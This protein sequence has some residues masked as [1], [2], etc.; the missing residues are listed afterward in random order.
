MRVLV[1]GA[2]AVGCAFYR[3]LEQQKGNE[4]T[5]LVRAGRKRGF[6]RFKILDARTGEMRTRERPL[7]VE[8][9]QARPGYDTVLFCVRADQLAAA[10]DD[11]GE[12]PAGAR[13]ATIT[14]GRDGLALLRERHP[15]HAAVRIA[16]AFMA[17]LDGDAIVTW[18]PPLVKTPIAHEQGGDDDARFAEELASAL[19][20]GGVPARAVAHMPAGL[21]AGTDAFMP[22]LAAYALSNYD[23]DTLV[24]DRALLALVGAATGEALTIA[25]APGFAGT[26][27][28]YAF[29]P[30][31]RAAL[32]AAAPRLPETFRAM[33]RTHVPK[34][35]KQTRDAISA[36]SKR[37]HEG[38]RP[39][40][41]LDEVLRRLDAL[42]P[43]PIETP[44]PADAPIGPT[45]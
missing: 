39:S 8:I 37:A 5:F 44:A 23:A 27:A 19:V 42:A 28:R 6:E 13:L 17:Y 7:C 32:V 31:V 18:A 38:G 20:A 11:V 21:D 10:L 15:G 34:I 25:G 33:W 4:A 9:G 12:L 24:R 2:G 26:L 36:L 16:P 35:E 43:A 41:S 14:P 22:L 45:A 29:A 30:V 40:P 1:V 3:A